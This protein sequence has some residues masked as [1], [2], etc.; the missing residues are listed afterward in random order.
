MSPNQEIK[1]DIQS[2]IIQIINKTEIHSEGFRSS[3]WGPILILITCRLHQYLLDTGSLFGW[4]LDQILRH[5]NRLDMICIDFQAL[6][7][8]FICIQGMQL[9]SDSIAYAWNKPLPSLSWKFC[10]SLSYVTKFLSTSSFLSTMC[11]YQFTHF[12][13]EILQ[14]LCDTLFQILSYSWGKIYI[15]KLC[16][17]MHK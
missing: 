17:I 14:H 10:Q 3:C 4:G 12:P 11:N 5:K 7:C 2:Q 9:P 1:S 13:R 15:P 6:Y 8:Q 16:L